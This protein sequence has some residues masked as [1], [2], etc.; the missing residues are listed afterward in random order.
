M[1][2][3]ETT[4]RDGLVRTST[5]ACALGLG[6]FLAWA[7]FVPL[8]EGVTAGGKII[9]ENDRQVVQHFEGGI[10]E[11]IRV[12]EGDFV[13]AGAIV[14]TLRE[15]AS[16]SNRDQLQTQI[17]ALVAREARLEAMLAGSTAPDFSGLAAFDL[18]PINRQSL[19]SE[20]LNLFDADS[21]SL[22]AET[23][24]L[25][26]RA[27]AARRT[28]ALRA[29]Q[30]SGAETTLQVATEELSRFRTLLDSQMVRR[31]Q[32]TQLEREVAGLR[33]DIARLT[34]ERDEAAASS[35]DAERQIEQIRAERRQRASSELRDARAERLAAL[36]SLNAAQD[37]LDR[38]VIVAPVSGEVLNLTH[39]TPG[40]VVPPAETI[41]EIVPRE[42][43]VVA[44]VRVRPTDRASVYEG[45][46]VRTQ[47]S[48]Y[49]SW[50]TPRLEGEVMS[51]SA[52]LKTDPATGADFYEARILLATG[53]TSDDAALEITPGM[54][55]DAFIYSGHSRTTL[56]YLFAPLMESVFKGLRTG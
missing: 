49:R 12:R 40:A 45:Q 43:R 29:E 8:E 22:R 53:G 21:A 14:V 32:V 50:Q 34:S 5:Y 37:V 38:S 56:D 44:S 9:V 46:T 6:G 31:D 18:D 47:I 25:E 2:K 42:Q 24:I 11:A 7:G 16:L 15:T 1:T 41:M 20:E 17:A 33:A 13:E 51:L 3:S 48:A 35:R 54:P 28:A 55:V 23:A 30:I 39:T 52:D 10:V 4:P 26:Q 36:E 27:L 19:E